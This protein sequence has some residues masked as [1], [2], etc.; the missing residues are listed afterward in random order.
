MRDFE[1]VSVKKDELTQGNVEQI[2]FEVSQSDKFEALYRIIDVEE[3]FYG[4]V[5]CRTKV[6]V[7]DV[8]TKLN[9]R[10]LRAAALHG[11]V[12]QAQ[13]EKILRQFKSKSITVLVA[14]DVAARGIDVN[15]L[16]HVINHS[17]PQDPESYV[18]RIGRTGRAGKTGVAI[19]LVTPS[20]YRKLSAIKRVTNS[21]IARKPIPNVKKVVDA[22]KGRIKESINSIIEEENYKDLEDMASEILQ[23]NDPKTALAAL[24]KHAFKD[25]LNERNY[26]E[27]ADRSSRGN[28]G[29]D[30]SYVDRKGTA[31]L[32]VARG[33]NDGM[34]PRSLVEMIEKETGV[35]SSRIDDVRILDDFSFIAASFEDAET[36]IRSFQN[37]SDGGRSL[38]SRAKEKSSDRRDGGRREG[39][40]RRDGGRND[41]RGGD[42]GDRGGFKGNKR[43]Y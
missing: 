28:D 14:T 40:G 18:H 25:E 41:R 5:F 11:D 16:T 32:F 19:T 23:E 37:L 31:R 39:G 38:V 22:K 27:I 9:N 20:E 6:D 15:D 35:Q 36:I 33:K 7:D 17:L 4:V 26:R 3:A 43:R 34:N 42:R 1:I 10:G 24:L 21:D 30:R 12:S 8:V 29:G 13:R 2:Y